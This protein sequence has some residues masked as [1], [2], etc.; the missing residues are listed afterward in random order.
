MREFGEPKPQHDKKYVPVDSDGW[1][2]LK[3]IDLEPM[4]EHLDCPISLH[5]PQSEFDR[6]KDIASMTDESMS[7]TV[8]HLVKLGLMAYLTAYEHEERS[9]CEPYEEH[10][11]EFEERLLSEG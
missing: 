7:G 5:L 1:K 3:C 2:M 4:D 9:D 8:R 10:E 6:V 11:E